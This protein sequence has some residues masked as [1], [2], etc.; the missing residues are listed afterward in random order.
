MFL[1]ALAMRD[2]PA[3]WQAIDELLASSD[4]LLRSVV[5]QGLSYNPNERAAT[6]LG[7]A[8]EFETDANVR[9][10][11]ITALGWRHE[12]SRLTTLK[13]A[14]E[15][16]P[17]EPV[18]HAAT[19]GLQDALRSAPLVGNKPLWIVTQRPGTTHVT[20]IQDGVPYVMATDPGGV[21]AVVGLPQGTVSVRPTT[22]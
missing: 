21:L 4:P 18:R 6:L 8:Y 19:L 11:I 17:S 9:L 16:D 1:R 14:S 20:L 10:P 22:H 13:L 12:S 15:L 5:A 2:E 3:A 7:R